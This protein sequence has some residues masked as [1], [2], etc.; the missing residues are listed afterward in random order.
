[1]PPIRRAL[2]HTG[3]VRKLLI[4]LIVLAI[5]LAIADF[6]L[7]AYA[8]SRTASAVQAQLGTATAPDVSIEGFPFLLHAAR[9]EYPQVVLTADALGNGAPAGTRLVL[10]LFDVTLPTDQALAGD[11]SNLRAQSTALNVLI[12][13]ATVEAALNRSDVA[14]SAGPDGTLQVATTVSVLGQQVPVSGTARL[15][16]TDNVLN[17]SV[18]SLSAA[19]IDLGPAVTSAVNSL[20]GSLATTIPLDGL[21]L[22]ITDA[23]I[24]IVGA[25]ISITVST[26]QVLFSDLAAARR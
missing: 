25:D 24:S 19:G 6:G 26:G 20:A 4:S 18:V 13:L 1:M 2:L 16:V 21:P 9:G 14:L 10:N 22:K 8:E 15:S 23:E 5:L 11:T 3:R 12:P 17:F 7:R